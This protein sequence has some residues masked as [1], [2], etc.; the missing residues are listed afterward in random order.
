[1]LWTKVQSWMQS[2]GAKIGCKGWTLNGCTE[3]G[4]KLDAKQLH[5]KLGARLDAKWLRRIRRK[6]GH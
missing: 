4:A 2:K 6:A 1:M 3:L 5:A